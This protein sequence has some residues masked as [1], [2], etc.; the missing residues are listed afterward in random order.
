MDRN[1]AI[2]LKRTLLDNIDHNAIEK[3]RMSDEEVQPLYLFSPIYPCA[4]IVHLIVTF[5]QE[6]ILLIDHCN[7]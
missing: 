4:I 6:N 5:V 1:H 3:F 2:K 7:S